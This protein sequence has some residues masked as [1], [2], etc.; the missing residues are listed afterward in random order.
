MRI[1][2]FNFKKMFAEKKPAKSVQT[3]VNINLD[4]NSIEEEKLDF[5]TKGNVIK[6]E[7]EFKVNYTPDIANLSLNGFV[8]ASLDKE[9]ALEI[10]KDWKDK[11]LKDGV[12]I[13]LFNLILTK[14]NVR[15]LQLEEELGLPSHLPLPRITS[16]T[17]Q[18]KNNA[19]YTG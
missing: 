4:I 3:Q 8:L 13:P 6:F 9:Q 17:K 5:M 2:G 7:F 15:A 16:E 10:L 19:N 18:E 12:R 11:K 14:C 1:I